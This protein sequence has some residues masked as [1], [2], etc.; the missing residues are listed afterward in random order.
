MMKM[1]MKIKRRINSSAR[2]LR[3]LMMV[4]KQRI[5]EQRDAGKN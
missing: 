2:H 5:E 4:I 3:Y 1:M